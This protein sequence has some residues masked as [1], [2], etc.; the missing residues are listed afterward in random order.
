MYLAAG[1]I[2][3]RGG[4]KTLSKG[5]RM[6]R[7]A[8][9]V[10]AVS[11]LSM[12]GL[13]LSAPAADTMRLATTPAGTFFWVM[14]KELS[15]LWGETG[16]PTEIVESATDHE[17]LDLL[18]SRKVDVALVSGPALKKYLGE[19]PDAPI[20]TLAAVWPSGVH[21]ILRDK[22]VKTNSP[23]DLN[24][25]KIYLGPARSTERETAVFILKALGV[26][27]NRYTPEVPDTSLL[28]VM[29]DFVKMEL[30]GALIVGPV[31]VPIVRDIIDGTGDNMRLIPATEDTARAIDTAGLPAFL[32]TIPKDTYPFQSDDLTIPAVGNYLVA[33]PDLPDGAAG[34]LVRSIFENVGRIARYFPQ[35]GFLSA[36]EGDAHLIVPLHP[37]AK[38]YF[39]ARRGK[40]R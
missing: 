23:N 40:N 1:S 30:D 18:S 2:P 14:G 19:H 7:T 4:R 31:P 22:F 10:L 28:S 24:G 27:T 6:R 36:D 13:P 3:R 8:L 17:N 35:G 9:L 12:V 15:T 11:M 32:L 21:L 16:L 5:V 34:L 39:D 25:R 37:G 38:G 26:A 33:R 29:T 20:V